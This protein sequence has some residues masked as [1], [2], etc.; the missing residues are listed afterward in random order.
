MMRVFELVEPKDP[1]KKPDA[2]RQICDCLEKG[3]DLWGAVRSVIGAGEQ[4]TNAHLSLL[5]LKLVMARD[6]PMQ[7]YLSS[8]LARHDEALLEQFARSVKR[9]YLEWRPST[10]SCV[11]LVATGDADP[12][13][14]FHLG[15][16]QVYSHVHHL[17]DEMMFFFKDPEFGKGLSLH[18]SAM[19]T[20]YLM[21][22]AWHKAEASVLQ[23]V[24]VWRHVLERRENALAL[25]ALTSRLGPRAALVH[26]WRELG[27]REA[28]LSSS[29]ATV[30]RA[31]ERAHYNKYRA[32]LT[33]EFPGYGRR[34]RVF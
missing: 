4:V 17:R 3:E 28:A 30:Y 33:E 29:A 9:V 18:P 16:E 7:G 11:L 24:E 25:A 21:D 2:F 26:A 19:T 27:L 32:T 8:H 20:P 13:F 14:K 10:K 5:N 23:Q 6:E 31:F 12:L 34:R 1:I 22:G 15:A